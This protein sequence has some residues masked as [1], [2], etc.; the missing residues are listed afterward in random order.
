[1]VEWTIYNYRE[2]VGDFPN[3][4]TLRFCDGIRD[5]TTSAGTF[6][7]LGKLVSIGSTKETIRSTGQK[8]AIGIAG[9]PDTEVKTILASDIKG[10]KI[11]LYRQFQYPGTNS[12][13]SDLDFPYSTGGVVGRFAGFVNTYSINDDIQLNTQI[14]TVE[15]VLDCVNFSG[16]LSKQV[17]GMRTN[18]SDIKYLSRDT[19]AGFDNVPTLY[20]NEWFFGAAK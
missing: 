5:I 1:M 12:A 7:A 11:S 13:I 20:E 15:I 3:V 9:I 8:V 6:T 2:N 14:R 10:S 17:R 18:P 19:E 4:Q 16:L